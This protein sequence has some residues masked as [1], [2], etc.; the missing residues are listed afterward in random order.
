MKT[1][2]ALNFFQLPCPA[3]PSG[4]GINPV[5]K[6]TIWLILSASK[7]VVTN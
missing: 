1:F 3:V 4:N 7:I 6:T 5:K 2:S